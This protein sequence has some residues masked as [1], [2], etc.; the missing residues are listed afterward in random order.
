[1]SAHHPKFIAVCGFP[2]VGKSTV[3]SY[4]ADSL[5]CVRL[6]SDVVRKELVDE[7]T[8]TDAERNHVYDELLSR[9][10]AVVERDQPVVV[11]ATFSEKGHREAARRVASTHE[12]DFRLIRVVCDPAVVERRI[13]ARDDISDADVSVYREFQTA[14]DSL[15]LDHATVD[16]SRSLAETREQVDALFS[17]HPQRL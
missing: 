16:N 9:A 1:M 15:E 7:P 11:D 10:G 12:V 13:E 5:D 4:V 3:S 8:Y 14:F 17:G 2:G 6:R